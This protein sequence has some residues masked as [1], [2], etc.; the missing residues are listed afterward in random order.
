MH[1]TECGSNVRLSAM[2]TPDPQIKEKEYEETG[3]KRQYNCEGNSLGSF[4]IVCY[5]GM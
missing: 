2:H 4:V 3:W 1:A 5:A